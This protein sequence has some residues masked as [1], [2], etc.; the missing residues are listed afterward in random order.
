M[1][2]VF[3][4]SSLL[5]LVKYYLPFD[6]NSTL[7]G[8]IEQHLVSGDMIIIDE[9]LN[10]CKGMAQGLVISKLPFLG[11]STFLKQHKIIKHTESLVPPSQRRFSN[12]LNNQFVNA[13]LRKDITDGEFEVIKNEFLRKADARMIIFLLNEINKNPSNNY[14]LITEETKSNNDNKYFIKLPSICEHLNIRCMNLPTYIAQK[15]TLKIDI[16]S[17]S[18][19]N[20]S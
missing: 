20:N 12:M 9:V 5:S 15:G 18:D 6:N 10:E 17:T 4:T 8:Q 14:A 16:S 2:A 11:E 1:K 3:D 19:T 13:T 7:L